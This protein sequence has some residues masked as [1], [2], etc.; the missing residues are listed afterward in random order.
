VCGVTALVHL[1]L[2]LQPA[3]HH[4]V[5]VDDAPDAPTGSTT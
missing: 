4:H 5:G 2:L 1:L 3:G